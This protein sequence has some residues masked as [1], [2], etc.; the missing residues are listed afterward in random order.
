MSLKINKPN[1]PS[2][3]VTNVNPYVFPPD[4]NDSEMVTRVANQDVYSYE[5]S[6]FN[7]ADSFANLSFTG[8][9]PTFGVNQ[10]WRG[11]VLA[12]N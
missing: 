12:P 1:K 4:G 5:Q 11:S 3:A 10:G 9:G 6:Y 7:G 8:M 2:F